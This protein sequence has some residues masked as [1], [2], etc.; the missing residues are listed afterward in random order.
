MRKTI[1]SRNSVGFVVVT[2]TTLF[3]FEQWEIHGKNQTK[4]LID[5]VC[6]GK[7]IHFYGGCSNCHVWLREGTLICEIYDGIERPKSPAVLTNRA[8]FFP[9]S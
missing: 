4:I 3:P 9:P 2:L 6:D 7:S 8:W 5:E 1:L